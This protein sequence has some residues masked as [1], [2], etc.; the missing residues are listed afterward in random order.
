[1][2]FASI[3]S[4]FMQYQDALGAVEDRQSALLSRGF[5]EEAKGTDFHAPGSVQEDHLELLSV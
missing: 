4:K 2:L 3:T 5:S 1:M